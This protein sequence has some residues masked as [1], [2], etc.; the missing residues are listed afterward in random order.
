MKYK[1]CFFILFQC[2]IVWNHQV[3]NLFGVFLVLCFDSSAV[4]LS[5]SLYRLTSKRANNNFFLAVNFGFQVGLFTQLC[6]WIGLRIVHGRHTIV[7]NLPRPN[8]CNM[9][10]QHSLLQHCLAQHVA[11]V[12]PPCCDMLGCCLKFDHFQTWANN[13]QHVATHRNTVAK[14]TQHVAPN[15]VAI[16]YVDMLRSFG[17]GLTRTNEYTVTS[18]TR[19]RKMY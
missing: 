15:N 13:T 5:F 9:S 19:Q 16:C 7:R 8:D 10:T 11:C 1:C 14:R 3:L 18:D 2:E 17:R 12:W 6:P 4:T